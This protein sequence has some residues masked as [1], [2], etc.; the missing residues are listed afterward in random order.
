MLD[1]QDDQKS[2]KCKHEKIYYILKWIFLKKPQTNCI[3]NHPAL[4]KIKAGLCKHNWFSLKY[5]LWETCMQ[6]VF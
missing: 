6:F 4:L 1:L 5:C 2:L 3:K